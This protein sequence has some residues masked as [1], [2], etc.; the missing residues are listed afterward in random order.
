MT[1]LPLGLPMRR[2]VDRTAA[3]AL[4]EELGLGGAMTRAIAAL[5]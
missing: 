2:P 1:D 4:G 3:E 5:S